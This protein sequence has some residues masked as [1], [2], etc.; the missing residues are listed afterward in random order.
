MT[1]PPPPCTGIGF[2]LQKRQLRPRKV[3]LVSQDYVTPKD[4]INNAIYIDKS[5]VLM[6]F[7]FPACP[8]SLAAGPAPRACKQCGRSGPGCRKPPVT[9]PRLWSGVVG[10][11][12]LTLCVCAERRGQWSVCWGSQAHRRP[13][14][15]ASPP[16]HGCPA[17]CPGT[18]PSTH[19]PP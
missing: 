7:C 19:P 6:V 8:C 17:T 9:A 4:E 2:L 18:P 11:F 13:L 14:P 5:S 1:P 10:L 3:R 12:T 15:A 16:T